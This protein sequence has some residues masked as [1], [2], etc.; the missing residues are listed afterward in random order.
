MTDLTTPSWAAADKATWRW[1]ALRSGLALLERELLL[2]RRQL[3]DFLS[4][5]LTQP[6]MFIFVFT[7][8]YPRIPGSGLSSAHFGTVILPG[9][10][11]FAALFCGIFAVGVPLSIDLGQSREIDDRALAPLPTWAIP[12]LRVASAVVQAAVTAAL[13]IPLMVL[14]ARHHPILNISAPL[15][16]FSLLLAAFMAGAI[17]VFVGGLVSP[18]RLP[19]VLAAVQIPLTFLGAGY[20]PWVSLNHIPVLKALILLNPVVYMSEALRAA[21]TPSIPH[22]NPAVCLPVG[23]AYGAIIALLGSRGVVRQIRLVGDR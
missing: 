14:L 13:V 12:A 4:R 11:A 23:F 3:G 18:I 5:S 17:G 20:F 6:L 8:V 22:M 10:M 19:T 9:I 15:L 21:L 1:L 16:V 2:F 7:F